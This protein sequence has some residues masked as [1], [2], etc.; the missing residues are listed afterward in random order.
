[1]ASPTPSLSEARAMRLAT[2]ALWRAECLRGGGVR[3]LV[4]ERDVMLRESAG[5]GTGVFAK[6]DI[7]AGTMVNRYWGALRRRVAQD[8]ATDAWLTSGLYAL[9]LGDEWVVDSEDAG[10]SSWA[11][12][13]NHSVRLQNVQA[14][15]VDPPRWLQSTL[16]SPYAIWLEAS[17]DIA[18]GEELRCDYGEEYW[19]AQ[20][21]LVPLPLDKGTPLYQL[22]ARLNPRRVAIDY[23]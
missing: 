13:I 18:A 17:R 1:M 11:R 15:Y 19:D 4:L 21:A 9:S 14:V 5:R 3:P 22:N 20:T 6:V 23:F 16:P 8:A 7:P 10:S 2:D 12:Y